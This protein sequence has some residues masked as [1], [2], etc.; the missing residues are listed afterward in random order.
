MSLSSTIQRWLRIDG[1]N[2]VALVNEQSLEAY[3]AQIPTS[4]K[5]EARDRLEQ[6]GSDATTGTV[7]DTTAE[8]L[9]AVVRDRAPETI[10]ETG[11]CN[12]WST[13]HLLLAL[14][15]N[16][17]GQL[18]S[19]DYPFRADESLEEFR[20]E[21]YEEF[22]GAVI[23]ADEEPGWII[24]DDLRG[25]WDL[26]KGKSQRELPRL[27]ADLG[28]IDMFV[29]DS[30]HSHACMMMEMELAWEHLSPNGILVVDD[31]SWTDAWDVWLNER[32]PEEHG[33][34]DIDVGF[35]IK[36]ER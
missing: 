27:L 21:I 17:A 32:E 16:G 8:R 11:V 6:L 35:A 9:Y 29:H 4:P 7:G 28:S 33:L 18:F 14:E 20:A 23:P 12:G 30:E 15:D 34:L 3:R 2:R 5:D 10:V 31:V 22:G 13:L 26:R 25:R 19:I 36:G 24:P 1:A